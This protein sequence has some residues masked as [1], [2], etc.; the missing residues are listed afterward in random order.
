MKLAKGI[1]LPVL[2]LGLMGLYIGHDR[3]GTNSRPRVSDKNDGVVS[4]KKLL[5]DLGIDYDILEQEMAALIE[6]GN[7]EKVLEFYSKY[8]SEDNRHAGFFNTYG[9]ACVKSDR[10]EAAYQAFKRSFLLDV[11]DVVVLYNLVSMAFR[12]ERYGIAH[13]LAEIYLVLTKDDLRYVRQRGLIREVFKST[14]RNPEEPNPSLKPPSLA[15]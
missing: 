14:K 10:F 9:V 8:I 15:V 13:Y 2:M 12:T 4:G 11:D 7:F 1:L 6:K 5:P 3:V